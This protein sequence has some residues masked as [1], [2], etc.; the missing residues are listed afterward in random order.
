MY[1]RADLKAT[2]KQNLK[3]NLI[4]LILA[5]LICGLITAIPIVGIIVAPVLYIGMIYMI[6]NVSNGQTA[7]IGMVFERISI[8]VKS[9]GLYFMI[10][11]F[12]MLW[13]MLFFIPGII[14]AISYSMAP[15]VM[16]ENPEKGVFEAIDDSKRMM[17]GHKMNYFVLMLSFIPWALLCGITFGLATLYVGPYM[18]VTV[19][20]F[21]K[22]VKALDAGTVQNA[23][24]AAPQQPQYQQPQ[25][26][27]PQYQ[28][29]QYQQPQQPQY[30]QPQQPQY[31][32]PQQPQYQ[33]P[34]QPQYQQPQQPQDPQQPMQ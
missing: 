15:Y 2:A 31:Q 5:I 25:Y 19:A 13:S 12:T 17:F 6:I 22:Q 29:P 24:Y 11:L 1:T 3:G 33:Q 27:Q 8:L 10:G 18:Q 9:F 23:A 32:Q 7:E 4:M 21:Y 14:K 30:Q 26:A 16:A 34:Q 20:N 28:Q